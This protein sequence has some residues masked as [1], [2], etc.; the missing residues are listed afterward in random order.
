MAKK[1]KIKKPDSGNKNQK[2]K[3]PS[4]IINFDLR[5]PLFSLERLQAGEYCF[6]V[7]SKD[8]KA[9]FAEAIFKRRETTWGQLKLL[10]RHALGL[11]KIS[12]SSIKA[13]PPKNI[14]E[15]ENHFLAFRFNGLCPMVGYRVND[16]FYI[17]WFNHNFTLYSH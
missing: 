14:K 10:D 3:E 5:P 2:I 8:F 9:A 16:I 11:E 15:D 13:A 7:L 6:S 4:E 1:P 12:K 17:L